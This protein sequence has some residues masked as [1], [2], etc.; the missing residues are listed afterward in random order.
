MVYFAV[1]R[2]LRNLLTVKIRQ[3]F[4]LFSVSG[5]VWWNGVMPQRLL[6]RRIWRF[7]LPI[8]SGVKCAGGLCFTSSPS[9]I[10][11]R[12]YLV[13]VRGIMKLSVFSENVMILNLYWIWGTRYGCHIFKV[14]V[15]I[16]TQRCFSA[17]TRDLCVRGRGSEGEMSE[18]KVIW[19]AVSYSIS[20]R[21]E[22]FR[23]E[24]RLK[25]FFT[26]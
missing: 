15:K 26:L 14:V 24:E 22:K 5:A 21:T 19:F 16:W 6:L 7:V 17:L 20:L 25:H 18:D 13:E 23:L 2:L 4:G 10:N 8:W 11:L 3:T 1:V 12:S 9:H